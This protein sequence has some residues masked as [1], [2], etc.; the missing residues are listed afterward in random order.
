MYGRKRKY[1]STG[2]GGEVR[3]PKR[4]Q[5]RQGSYV[6]PSRSWPRYPRRRAFSNRRTASQVIIRQPST[7]PDRLYVKLVYRQSVAFSTSGTLQDN[8]F[9]GNSLNDPDLTGAGGQPMGHDQW[10][11]LYASYTVLGSKIEVTCIQNGGAAAYN[12]R[13]G[14]TPINFSSVFGT[15][16]FEVA[17][18]T[19]YSKVGTC[20]MGAAGIGQA[21]VRN[22][23][24]TAK[25]LG[26]VRPAV[27][28][29]DAYGALINANPTNTWFWHVWAYPPG[30]GDKSVIMN[31][32]LTYYAVYE[33][34]QQLA[35]S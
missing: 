1:P 4:F 12:A 11:S 18:E 16:D 3:S 22:Y 29:E 26:V 13:F 8:V 19:V 27:Q 15:S 9:R 6:L 30:G 5:G 33:T 32:R 14:V 25:L 10:S 2:F 31:V 17:E 21:Q 24:S 23:M 20:V 35:V 7:L 34:R 28:I